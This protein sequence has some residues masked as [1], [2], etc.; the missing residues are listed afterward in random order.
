MEILGVRIENLEKETILQRIECFL[1]EDKFHQIATVNPEFILEAQKDKNF[2]NILNDCDLN[3]ADGI[4]IR[5]AFWKKR[6]RLKCR[7]AGADL[8]EE[9]LRR[10][11]K[12]NLGVFLVI[13]SGGLSTWEEARDAILRKYP[14][15]EVNGV[16]LNKEISNLE[17]RI[18]NKARISNDLISEEFKNSKL[19]YLNLIKISELKI[20]NYDIIFCNFGA[21][22]QEKFL[23]SL[24]SLENSKIKLAMGVGGSFDYLTGKIKRAPVWMRRIGLE[25]LWRLIQQPKRIKRIFNAVIIFPLR[26]IFSKK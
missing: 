7:T 4:G 6:N 17:F 10:A 22:Y 8:V 19:E 23:S 16:N 21:P 13:N 15:L 1:G 20:Q 9:I 26:F 3:V 2:K 12:N 5:L 18:S 14:A 24:K 25:W 11:E